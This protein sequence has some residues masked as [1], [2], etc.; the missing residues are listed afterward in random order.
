MSEASAWKC[1]VC[2]YVHREASAPDA[3]PVCGA[4][5]AAFQSLDDDAT[6]PAIAERVE[7][8]G[9]GSRWRC[10]I[11]GYI[12]DGDAPPE[13]CP[14]CG[15]AADLFET[16]EQPVESSPAIAVGSVT[17][18]PRIVIIGAGIAGLSAAEAARDASPGAEI[19]LISKEDRLPYYRLNLTRYLAG[20]VADDEL[21]I[22]PQSWYDERR[23][24]LRQGVEVSRIDVDDGYVALSDGSDETY[25]RL[26]LANGAHPFIPPVMGANREGVIAVRTKDDA[27]RLL[28]IARPGA[29]VAVMGGG[30]LGLETAGALA[31][32][33]AS[34]T[35]LESYGYL[36]PRQLNERAAALLKRRVEAIGVEIASS[37]RA[38]EIVGDE[39]ARGV[40]LDDGRAFD[41]D[42]VAIC[43][44][45]RPNSYLARLVGLEVNVG[46]AVDNQ[47]RT[48][49]PEIL[50]A[51]DVAEHN[52]VCYGIWA[53][54]QYQGAIAGV[55]AAG[56][57]SEFGGIPRANT[58]KVLGVDLVSIGQV[59]S[60]DGSFVTI[61]SEADGVYQ[62]YLVHDGAMV[63][64]IFVGDA[65]LA[66]A[67]HEAIEKRRDLS[68]VMRNAPSADDVADW[69]KAH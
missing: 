49:R 21:P 16:V 38:K 41:A 19:V 47:M 7:S 2:G 65:S 35:V 3:C 69:L 56:G 44:G 12:H 51:G 22:H 55:N 63:G 6:I 34:V 29:R 30:V 53:P 11:C 43:A 8:G 62:R 50:V 28:A 46:V 58:L 52:G 9:T 23:I 37:A 42:A 25:D 32:R 20:E 14:I 13:K 48:S 57:S 1:Q 33:G 24:D 60:T 18:G 4:G 59:E 39:R 40:V 17:D 45:V 10:A 68:A 36:M 27:D 5:G 26:I 61:E 54:A 67:A 15:A 64:A 31:A 66:A